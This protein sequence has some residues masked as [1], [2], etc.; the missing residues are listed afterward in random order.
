MFRTELA[1]NGMAGGGGPLAELAHGSRC[2][3]GDSPPL[4]PCDS[5]LTLLWRFAT[6]KAFAAHAVSPLQ[7]TTA[8]GPFHVTSLLLWWVMMRKQANMT[9]QNAAGER[10]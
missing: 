1:V 10:N 7:P 9:M 3:N 4:A 8:A 2:H 5:I 6:A